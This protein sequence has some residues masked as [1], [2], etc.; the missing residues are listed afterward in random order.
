MG[1]TSTTYA[2]QALPLAAPHATWEAPRDV[3]GAPEPQAQSLAGW[4]AGALGALTRARAPLVRAAAEGETLVLR[5]QMTV[6]LG[7]D[8][9]PARREAIDWGS[10]P[11]DV[12]ECPFSSA[13]KAQ[14]ILSLS[15]QPLRVPTSSRSSR[16]RW[17]HPHRSQSAVRRPSRPCR[18]CRCPPRPPLQAWAARLS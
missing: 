3:G 18:P 2:I 9:S 10:V 5:E 15:T 11:D 16:P 1:Y 6:F 14:L 7:A 4:G 8:G 13:E 12:G 17:A